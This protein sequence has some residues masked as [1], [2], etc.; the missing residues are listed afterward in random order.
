MW[1]F[2]ICLSIFFTYTSW[3]VV[4]V[5]L[6]IHVFVAVLVGFSISLNLSIK[7]VGMLK[8]ECTHE[9]RLSLSLCVSTILVSYCIFFFL[10]LLVWVVYRLDSSLEVDV[11]SSGE[12]HLLFHSTIYSCFISWAY[13][14]TFVLLWFLLLF[15]FFLVSFVLHIWTG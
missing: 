2:I 14:L 5:V 3:I 6:T 13:Y 9:T 11:L 4:S 10:V 12:S 1:L 8:T 15:F 7:S